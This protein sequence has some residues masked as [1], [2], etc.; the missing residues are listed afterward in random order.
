MG[1]KLMDNKEQ[2]KKAPSKKELM[3]EI[4]QLDTKGL[5]DYVSLSRTNSANI[6]AV[7]VLLKG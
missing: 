5:F 4:E 6:K 3:R 2:K 7:A 1:D